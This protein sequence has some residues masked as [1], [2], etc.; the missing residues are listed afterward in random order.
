[1]RERAQT[2]KVVKGGGEE[3]HLLVN[4]RLD[5][6]GIGRGVTTT[7]LQPLGKVMRASSGSR[8]KR[9]I[10]LIGGRRRDSDIN[11]SISEGGG[12]RVALVVGV[13]EKANVSGAGG[14]GSRDEVSGFGGDRVAGDNETGK[15][16][17]FAADRA[18]GVADGVAWG[19]FVEVAGKEVVAVGVKGAVAEAAGGMWKELGENGQAEAAEES[20]AVVGG[21]KAVVGIE[22]GEIVE[23]KGHHRVGKGGEVG[24][25]VGWGGKRGGESG[26][27]L[28]LEASVDVAAEVREADGAISEVG[29]R[30]RSDEGREMGGKEGG[31][32]GAEEGALATG[33]GGPGEEVCAVCRGEVG[34]RSGRV[35]DAVDGK[36]NGAGVGEDK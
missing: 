28:F 35:R 26:E 36:E 29:K 6:G 21:G 4:H 17:E 5:D 22:A 27:I 19:G 16:G 2:T 1:V 32:S 3:E 30:G 15:G 20:Q 23:G 9:C 14:G 13:E 11:D 7:E 12:G 25:N 8:C 18:K 10:T 34:D 24:A 31:A 33:M